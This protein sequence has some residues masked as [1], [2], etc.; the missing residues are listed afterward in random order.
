M[1]TNGTGRPRDVY[2]IECD[3]RRR[4][5][6]YNASVIG[7]PSDH[8]A[9]KWYFLPYPV[10]LGVGELVSGSFDTAADAERAARAA[11]ARGAAQRGAPESPGGAAPTRSDTPRLPLTPASGQRPSTTRPRRSPLS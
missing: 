1:P 2:K 4:Y 6:V 7:N 9:D 10:P 3:D 11:H 5:V 8:V